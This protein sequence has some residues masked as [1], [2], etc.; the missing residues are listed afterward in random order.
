MPRTKEQFQKMR[1]ARKERILLE[2]AKAFAIEGYDSVTVDKIVEKAKCSHGLFYHY[3]KNKEDIYRALL[4]RLTFDKF[5][6][7]QESLNYLEPIDAL[8]K[9]AQIY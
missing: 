1:D 8:R 2:S 5:D 9:F 4:A 7:Y 3:F 6:Q